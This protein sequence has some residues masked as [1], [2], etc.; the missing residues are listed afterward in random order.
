MDGNTRPLSSELAPRQRI[1]SVPTDDLT[2]LLESDSDVE[3]ITDELPEV[4]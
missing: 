3:E 4:P 1:Q 2:G